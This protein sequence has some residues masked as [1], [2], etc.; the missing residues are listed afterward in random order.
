MEQLRKR[1]VVGVWKQH[2]RYQYK[3]AKWKNTNFCF[4]HEYRLNWNNCVRVTRVTLWHSAWR[5]YSGKHS[6]VPRSKQSGHWR[7]VHVNL[8]R[9][10]P[11]VY[12]HTHTHLHI[13]AGSRTESWLLLHSPRTYFRLRLPSWRVFMQF[14]SQKL[15]RNEAPG[16]NPPSKR[17][18]CVCEYGNRL[19]FKFDKFE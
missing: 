1:E 8:I 4:E 15:P 17:R 12:T 11:H 14:H 18:F 3:P 6:S 7:I 2:C 16:F 13:H 10:K 9:P 5:H 19:E